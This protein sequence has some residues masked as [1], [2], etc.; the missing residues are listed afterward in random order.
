M[1]TSELVRTHHLKRN[2]VI[3]IRQSTP[4][5]VFTNQESPHVRYALR[6]RAIELGWHAHAIEVANANLGLT[7]VAAEHRTGFKELV[8]QV[9]LG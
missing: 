1:N 3:Y 7:A 8:A 2:A 6:Q 9:T 5:Q 4:H